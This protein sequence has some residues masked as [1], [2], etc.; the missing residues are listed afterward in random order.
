MRIHVLLAVI[1]I[2]SFALAQGM[3]G[4]DAS[5]GLGSPTY[6]TKA[7]PAA[8]EAEV[9]IENSDLVIQNAQDVLRQLG[10]EIN[11]T[12]PAPSRKPKA[13][14]ER[15]NAEPLE[16]KA[17]SKPPVPVKDLP[18]IASNNA[19]PRLELNFEPEQIALEAL[20]KSDILEQIFIP[21]KENSD[22]RVFI[23][24]HAASPDKQQS[25]SRR[26][27]LKR[28]L[29]IQSFLESKGIEPTKLIVLPMGNTV[30]NAHR[31]N[32]ELSRL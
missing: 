19:S 4:Y 23:H 15:V 5:K 28:A 16:L 32:L 30:Q 7:P 2:P 8:V 11:E 6:K 26:A 20:Q 29:E 9:I 22:M 21:L 17:P 24:S 12:P 18:D 10:G 27:S 3:D 31:I 13:G 14:I 25:T 1:L